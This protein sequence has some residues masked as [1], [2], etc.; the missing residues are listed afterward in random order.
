MGDNIKVEPREVDFE[1]G[2]WMELVR[3][4]PNGGVIYVECLASTRLHLF[5][6]FSWVLWETLAFTFRINKFVM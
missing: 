2:R 3:I 6:F 5:T 4:V 1:N